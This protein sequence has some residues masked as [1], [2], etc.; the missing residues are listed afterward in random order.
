M[1]ATVSIDE[2][3]CDG[4]ENKFITEGQE[5][6]STDLIQL[7]DRVKYGVS[8]IQA[9]TLSKLVDILNKIEYSNQGEIGENARSIKNTI[10]IYLAS[11]DDFKF[12]LRQVSEE[13]LDKKSQVSLLR[14]ELKD[15]MTKKAQ[16]ER[17]IQ[18]LVC[19][20]QKLEDNH[21][22]LIDSIYSSHSSSSTS[23][24][25]TSSSHS[26]VSQC[27]SENFIYS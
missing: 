27:Q 21:G 22:F 10:C 4:I 16:L 13:I 17:K 19:E 7:A 15:I 14:N 5:I 25:S 9:D 3:P 1:T 23:T 6:L 18:P 26:Q 2:D 11:N 20:L 24:S 8:Q 12:K